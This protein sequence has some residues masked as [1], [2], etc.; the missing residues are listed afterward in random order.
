MNHLRA[1]MDPKS[2]EELL[3]LYF[4]LKELWAN[5]ASIIDKAIAQDKREKTE[6]KAVTAAAAAT[7]AADTSTAEDFQIRYIFFSQ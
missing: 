5:D 3:F 7:L 1:H 6:A 4:N 2:L